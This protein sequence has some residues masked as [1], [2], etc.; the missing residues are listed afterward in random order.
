MSIWLCRAGR[1][2]EYEAHFMEE[3]KIFY[4]F[5]EIAVP[6]SSFGSKQDLKEYFV[7]ISPWRKENAYMI[8]AAQ[9]WI[10]LKNMSPGDWVVTPSKTY[11]GTLYF[12]EIMSDYTFDEKADESY[13]H[14]RD[15]KWFAKLKRDQFEQDIQFTFGT[16]MTIFKIKQEER[17][18]KIAASCSNFNTATTPPHPR[19]YVIW[20]LNHSRQYLNT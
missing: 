12:G 4:T 10:F 18:K 1:N 19:L 9:G 6:L 2:G 13:R 16:P 3:N 11:P 17:I 8:Y 7:K 5:E 20:K 14:Y 15:V